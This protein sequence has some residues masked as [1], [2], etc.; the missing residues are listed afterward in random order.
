MTLITLSF[1]DSETALRLELVCS[2]DETGNGPSLLSSINY[3]KTSAGTRTLRSNLLEPL[4]DAGA[5]ESRLDAVEELVRRPF[6]LYQPIK[7]RAINVNSPGTDVS[8]AGRVTSLARHFGVVSSAGSNRV[9][10][11]SVLPR[12]RSLAEAL[13]RNGEGEIRW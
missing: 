12:P 10:R 7:V 2:L 9:S 5:I 11:G 8:R 3:C 4:S 13:K 6:D 1:A